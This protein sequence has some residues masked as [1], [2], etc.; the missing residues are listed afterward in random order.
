MSIGYNTAPRR[1]ILY[2]GETP[3]QYLFRIGEH[4]KYLP[5]D[6]ILDAK[7][8]KI[9]AQF[10][11][12]VIVAPEDPPPKLDYRVPGISGGGKYGYYSSSWDAQKGVFQAPA[13]GFGLPKSI[14]GSFCVSDSDWSHLV[15]PNMDGPM[16]PVTARAAHRDP[17]KPIA[18]GMPDLNTNPVRSDNVFGLPHDQF[19]SFCHPDA[20]TNSP[21]SSRPPPPLVVKNKHLQRVRKQ[22]RAEP[23]GNVHSPPLCPNSDPRPLSRCAST[24]ILRP[25]GRT[26]EPE[27]K[28]ETG[29]QIP[30]SGVLDTK[31]EVE[32]EGH[33]VL[34]ADGMSVVKK[35]MV[36][37]V[38]QAPLPQR[39]IY[40]EDSGIVLEDTIMFDNDDDINVDAFQDSMASAS[41]SQ[42]TNAP[43]GNTLY[44]FPSQDS[45]YGTQLVNS[46][47]LDYFSPLSAHPDSD[48]ETFTPT[49]VKK[50]RKKAIPK[51]AAIRR[52]TRIKEKSVS[53][54]SQSQSYP[55][56]TLGKRNRSSQTPD[57]GVDARAGAGAGSKRKR[58]GQEDTFL[59]SRS[60]Q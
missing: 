19:T 38:H 33:G 6:H 56:S 25:E 22:M 32:V 27:A 42:D 30:A 20:Q 40:L 35:G 8:K 37:E 52:S 51:P 17:Q 15:A 9:I 18:R 13:G 54:A 41:S 48:A 45:T 31:L 4:L 28:V 49:K 3:S 60:G 46:Q 5:A 24:G 2:R 14:N 47:E 43:P 53:Q 29:V 44:T 23:R 39:D 7:T 55:S 59:F 11:D 16:A 36:E 10:L 50:L 57:A 58:N 12:K 1:K 26:K 34:K 21:S